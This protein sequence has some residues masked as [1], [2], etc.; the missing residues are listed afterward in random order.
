MWV[1]SE[2]AVVTQHNKNHHTQNQVNN[3]ILNMSIHFYSNIH[4]DTF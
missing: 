2:Y 3:D 4:T 1:K